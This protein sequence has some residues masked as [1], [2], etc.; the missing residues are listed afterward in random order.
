MSWNQAPSKNQSSKSLDYQPLI[1]KHQ[2]VF[3]PRISLALHLVAGLKSF[4]RKLNHNMHML[5]D[6]YQGEVTISTPCGHP[7][8]KNNR[9]RKKF[10]QCLI[11]IHF[12]LAPLLS[13]LT[14]K[15]NP[16][17]YLKFSAKRTM[18]VQKIAQ[19]TPVASSVACATFHNHFK[20][21]KCKPA[22]F[23]TAPQMIPLYFIVI[24][25]ISTLLAKVQVLP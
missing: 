24:L 8:L 10:M 12:K 13:L 14:R 4:N 11:D 2:N 18:Q 3:I 25:G 7:R 9:T 21:Q 22:V 16:L 1:N 15:L 20:I 6:V 23:Q 17:I 19:F 5:R